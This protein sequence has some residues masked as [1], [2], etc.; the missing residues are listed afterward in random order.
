MSKISKAIE[1]KQH[2]RVALQEPM[3]LTVVDCGIEEVKYEDA[4]CYSVGVRLGMKVRCK[5]SELSL[6]QKQAR[7]AIINEIFGEFKDPI[8]KVYEALCDRDFDK[9]MKAMIELENLMFWDDE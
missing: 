8:I 7:R 2:G 1:T 3:R 5:P 6:V 4:Y 9:A